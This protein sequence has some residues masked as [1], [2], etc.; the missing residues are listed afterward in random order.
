[1]MVTG[2]GQRR[3]CTDMLLRFYGRLRTIIGRRCYEV[4]VRSV[5]EAMRFLSVN[6]TQ[7]HEYL[8]HT[9]LTVLVNG[10]PIHDLQLCDYIGDGTIDLIPVAGGSQVASAISGDVLQGAA[11]DGLT[12][13]GLAQ[14]QI[15]ISTTKALS[16]GG[17]S[18]LLSP[19]PGIGNP[20]LGNYE[21]N[22]NDHPKNR[23]ELATTENGEK[24]Y[25]FSGI[26]NSSQPGSPL[27]IQYGMPIVG[28]I[29][30]SLGITVDERG[31]TK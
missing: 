30:I 1:M 31:K 25:N 29:V 24:T 7:I 13:F 23:P 22:S 19:I 11:L 10:M 26:S 17:T 20:S 8:E 12:L 21:G 28:S 14:S 27:P 15:D 18:Q 5:S 2:C 4:T 16:L 3:G 9:R 6:F